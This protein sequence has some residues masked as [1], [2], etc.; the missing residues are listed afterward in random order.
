MWLEIT[1]KNTPLLKGYFLLRTRLLTD[2]DIESHTYQPQA[3]RYAK[4]HKYM[5][6]GDK[7]PTPKDRSAGSI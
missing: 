4:A 1:T 6:L 3:E 2:T 5:G 7:P